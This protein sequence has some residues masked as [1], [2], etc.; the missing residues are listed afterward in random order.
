MIINQINDMFENLLRRDWYH[1][2]NITDD[3]INTYL[4]RT[5]AH[6]E[7]VMKYGKKIGKNYAD[8]DRD[9]LTKDNIIIPYIFL[10]WGK[11]HKDFEIPELIQ[12]SIDNAT[13]LHMINNKHHP[14]YWCDDNVRK[15]IDFTRDDPNPNG[16]IYDATKMPKSALDEM[17]CDWCAMAEEMGEKTPKTWADKTVNKRWKFTNEQTDYIYKMLD[18]VWNK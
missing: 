1:K 2:L 15:L 7:R 11:K 14:E 5:F 9:K 12:Q 8:H 10:T 4:D 3:M 18:K 6:I 17:V 13:K 16:D